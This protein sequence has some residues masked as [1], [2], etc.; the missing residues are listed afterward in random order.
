MSMRSGSIRLVGLASTALLVVAWGCGGP[1]VSTSSAEGTVTGKVTVDGKPAAKGRITYDPSNVERKFVPPNS[2]DIAED[3]S[4][5]VKTLV[6]K[7]RVSF[8]GN[9]LGKYE[10]TELE[11]DVKGGENTNDIAFPVAPPA[12]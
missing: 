10:F 3:G 2:A 5:S 4:Y 11:Y 12:P 7:N 1:E 9:T 6:G 8:S